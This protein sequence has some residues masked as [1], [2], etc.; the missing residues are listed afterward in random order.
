MLP[1]TKQH[2][3]TKTVAISLSNFEYVYCSF[4][5]ILPIVL[6]YSRHMAM[7]IE[8]EV[9]WNE[10]RDYLSSIKT[11]WTS[12]GNISPEHPINLFKETILP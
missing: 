4:R 8:H 11:R 2:T 1:M 9:L 6:Q 10:K 7:E 5:M 12:V 3:A